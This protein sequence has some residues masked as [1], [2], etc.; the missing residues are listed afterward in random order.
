M[1]LG[2]G[3]REQ[4][5]ERF[6]AARKY[7]LPSMNDSRYT[8]LQPLPPIVNPAKPSNRPPRLYRNSPDVTPE[9]RANNRLDDI[10]NAL[11]HARQETAE[12]YLERDEESMRLCPLKFGGVW[13]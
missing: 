11:G 7:K 10:S 12:V 9:D 1:G 6:R 8:P 3:H 5:P 13:S 4:C 2:Y